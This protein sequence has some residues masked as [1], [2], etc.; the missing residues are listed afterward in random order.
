MQVD[1][2]RNYCHMLREMWVT[3]RRVL[4]WM[5]EFI[6]TFYTQLLTTINYCSIAGL[7]TLQITR[8][9]LVFSLFTSRVLP[10]DL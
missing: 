5:I 9:R 2:I 8:T 4:D 1:F 3:Y 6:D 10:M 7:H